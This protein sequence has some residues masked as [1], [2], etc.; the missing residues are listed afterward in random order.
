MTMPEARQNGRKRA[1][2]AGEEAGRKD[3]V[4][5]VN[6][7]EKAFRVL[8]AFGRQHQ[9]LNLSQVASETGMDLSAAQRF[10]HT[11]TKLGY[12][13][14]DAQTKRFELTAKTLDLGYHFVRSSR[15]LDRAMPYLMH[16]S[17]E[18]EE[19]VNLTVRDGTEIIFVSRFLSR[20]VLN[21][22]VIIGT[23]MPAYCTAPGI[24]M[25]SR[26]PEDEAMA[27]ID[28]SDLKPHTPS[29]T[30]QREALREK[31]RQS[32]AQGY[33]TAFEEVYLGDAS[34]AAVIVDHHGQP[35]AAVNIAT[36]TSRYSHAEVVARFSSLVIATAHAISRV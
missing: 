6:S 14:K 28:A 15:L 18:T 19:T 4:L 3:D 24:A 8:S 16:L 5:M 23:R 21:T 33:A 12:L 20:H 31:L 17:K 30:W 7:V 26:L 27:I 11:L 35:E 32:A 29:T 9:T 34:I 10:T 25:L 36:S 13:R 1:A 22:D 2:S